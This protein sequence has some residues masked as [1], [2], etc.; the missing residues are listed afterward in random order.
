M[1]QL[2]HKA[3]V[4]IHRAGEHG[5]LEFLAL[6]FVEGGRTLRTLVE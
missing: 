5:G 3:V 4:G 1:A 2:H 6:E